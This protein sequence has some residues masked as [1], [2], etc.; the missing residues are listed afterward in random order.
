LYCLS[1]TEAIFL[2]ALVFERV[3][4]GEA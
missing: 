3:W 1:M 2:R 4:L